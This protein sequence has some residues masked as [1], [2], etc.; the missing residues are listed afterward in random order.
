MYSEWVPFLFHCKISFWLSPHL[1]W[2]SRVEP[3]VTKH[4]WVISFSVLEN[5]YTLLLY[6][7]HIPACNEHQENWIPRRSTYGLESCDFFLYIFEITEQNDRGRLWV[8]SPLLL[9]SLDFR[10][11]R[12]FVYPPDSWDLCFSSSGRRN[13]KISSNFK[14]RRNLWA[15]IRTGP[16]S[17]RPFHLQLSLSWDWFIP[18]VQHHTVDWEHRCVS[19]VF[20]R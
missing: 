17:W 11:Q 12:R 2:R 5:K 7:L 20:A 6:T 13:C 10:G 19:V 18:M 3:F 15:V 1:S 14:W 9:E 4:C 8:G 16:L